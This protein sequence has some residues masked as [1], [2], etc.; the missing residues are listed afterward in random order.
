MFCSFAA[1][2]VVLTDLGIQNSDCGQ[3][4]GF[5]GKVEGVDHHNEK[6]IITLDALF[7]ERVCHEMLI[8]VLGQVSNL[9]KKVSV[10]SNVHEQR[11]VA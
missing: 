7:G 1:L 5:L 10:H 11:L 6:W 4:V 8:C 3:D 9:S 2:D